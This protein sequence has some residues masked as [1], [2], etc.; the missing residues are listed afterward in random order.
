[1]GKGKGKRDR[2]RRPARRDAS[3]EPKP[4]ILCVCEGQATEPRYLEGFKAWCKNPRVEIEIDDSHGVPLT[5]VKRAWDRKKQAEADAKR[6]KDENLRFD[7]VWCVFDID[8]HPHIPEA[9]DMAAGNGIDLAISNA[10]FELW[11]ILHF[12]ESPGPQGR[13]DLVRIL[14]GFLPEYD[15]G[16]L[17][18][19]AFRD[20]YR[21]A[22]T[23][24]RHLDRDADST[25]WPGQNPTTGVWRLTESIRGGDGDEAKGDDSGDAG[26]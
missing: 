6:E 23:R 22:V 2:H 4:R 12:R 25:G 15:K 5:L 7:Q 13:Y 18:F 26:R 1:M 11:L 14:K 9:K 19:T 10:A 3:R 21:A 17:D 16:T 24:S 8:E 20:G